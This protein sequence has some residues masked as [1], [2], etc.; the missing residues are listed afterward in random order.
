MDCLA[1]E[2]CLV[3]LDLRVTLARMASRVKLVCQDPKG[4]K[5]QKVIWDLLEVEDHVVNEEKL[6]QSDHQEKKDLLD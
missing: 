6:D 4:S 3:L 5:A 2:D 1:S